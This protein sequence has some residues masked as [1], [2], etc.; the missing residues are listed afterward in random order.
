MTLGDRM[1]SYEHVYRTY[2]PRRTYTLL[3]LDGRAFHTFTRNF[4][5]P[6]DQLFIDAM[7]RTA[8]ALCAEITGTRFAYVQSDE[9][10]LL[11]T[12]FENHETQQ[13]VGGNLAKTLS[14]SA[15]CA[16]AM[17]NAA[18]GRGRPATFDSRVWTM[19]DANEVANY[20]IWRQRDCIKNSVSMLAQSHFSHKAL[21]GKSTDHRLDMLRESGVSWGDLSADLRQG[22]VVVKETYAGPEDSVRTRW[23]TQNAPTFVI[24]PGAGKFLTNMI[25][26]LPSLPDVYI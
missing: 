19:S 2:L 9:I 18:I 14:L 16:T 24:S 17:F 20:F 10:S 8:E 25:P 5:K 15:S 1:K 21:E 23:V 13:W 7:N 12:D 4:D 6:F 11:V 26:P 22:R 3:R